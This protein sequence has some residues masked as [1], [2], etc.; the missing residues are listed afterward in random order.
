LYVIRFEQIFNY[1]N[2]E[3]IHRKFPAQFKFAP[4]WNLNNCNYTQ[5]TCIKFIFHVLQT[6]YDLRVRVVFPGLVIIKAS[7]F[8]SYVLIY[9]FINGRLC[10]ELKKI[11]NTAMQLQLMKMQEYLSTAETL[12]NIKFKSVSMNICTVP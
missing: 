1:T 11:Y 9:V 5:R 10:C 3:N 12:Y 7:E 4:L 2:T 8:R 6:G